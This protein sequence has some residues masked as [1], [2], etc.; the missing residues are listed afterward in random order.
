MYF[1]SLIRCVGCGVIL[2]GA[3][4]ALAQP[5][6]IQSAP[7]DIA[8]WMYPFNASPANR[9]T[10]S[11]FSGFG[12]VGSFDTR[13]AQ[14]LLAWNT[15][16]SIPTGMGARSYLVSRVRVTLTIASG[17]QYIYRGTLR[18]YRAYF[19][20]NDPSYLPPA[21]TN[22]PVELFGAGFRG[23]YT[24]LTFPQDGPF[25]SAGGAYY[26]NR[27]AYAACFDTSGVLVD[28]S[29]NVGDDG[30]NEI[31]AAF[32]VAPF[33]VGQ[34]TNVS[35]GQ[36]MPAGSQLTFELNL[37][38]PL[39]YSYVQS[40]L[41]SGRLDFVAA[42][43]LAASYGGTPNYPNF[44]TPFNTLADPDQYPLL[45]IEGTVVRAYLDSDADGLPDDWEQFCFGRLGLGA[46]NSFT[47]D[48]VSNLAKYIAGTNPTNSANN[49]RLLSIQNQSGVTELRFTFAP[50][51]QYSFQWSDD[52]WHWQTVTN[53]P[54]TFSSAW[55]AKT[56]T[57]VTYP[58]PVYALWRDTNAVSSQRFYRGNVQ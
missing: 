20:T 36:L 31:A 11:V 5:F 46:T 22:C 13:D 41:D 43:L 18:D 51:R 3:T 9:A 37:D 57:N 1:S 40:G 50:S 49:F 48:G 24:A 55:L 52:L 34:T 45:D 29:N 30:T 33:A 19:P 2:S 25:K 53:P 32:E 7:S 12:S 23:G 56:G 44:Y 35:P 17:N 28:V 54:L 58:A 14:F 21:D 16:N 26:T 6:S 42:T 38:D 39:I 47:G 4:S 10:A 15:S 27:N 8:R